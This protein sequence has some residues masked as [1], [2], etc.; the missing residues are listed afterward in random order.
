MLESLHT[1]PVFVAYLLLYFNFHCVIF[2]SV[3]VFKTPYF[4]WDAH[5][6]YY[7]LKFDS[8]PR[9]LRRNVLIDELTYNLVAILH[10]IEQHM[11][12]MNSFTDLHSIIA[13]VLPFATVIGSVRNNIRIPT[14]HVK[15]ILYFL[16]ILFI[17]FF[18]DP[19]RIWLMFYLYKY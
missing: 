10:A 12:W 17:I 8:I 2:Y 13:T 1:S 4:F 6:L 19:L 5:G 18:L 3:S 15:H 9:C 11:S 7:F 16:Y 14:P